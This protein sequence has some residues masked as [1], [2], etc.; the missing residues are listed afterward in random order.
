MREPPN[1]AEFS[2]KIN[3][4]MKL[5]ASYMMTRALANEGELAEHYM[6]MLTTLTRGVSLLELMLEEEDLSKK[7]IEMA[8]VAMKHTNDKVRVEYERINQER[9]TGG[10]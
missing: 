6:I 5:F 3:E 1:F 9:I 10:N 7:H 8:K 2:K 4:E